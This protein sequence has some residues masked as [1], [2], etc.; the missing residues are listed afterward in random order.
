LAS[1]T[2]A[3]FSNSAASQPPASPASWAAM[4]RVEQPPRP[5]SVV[6]IQNP[7]I[8]VRVVEDLLDLRV[9]E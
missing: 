1:F 3:Y 9:G 2:P 6:A 7:Q 8:V 5:E 4:R